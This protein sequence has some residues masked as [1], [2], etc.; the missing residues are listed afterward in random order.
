MGQRL[1]GFG[2]LVLRP[3]LRG[4]TKTLGPLI[5]SALPVKSPWLNAIEATWVH[6]KRRV[7]E[8]DRLLTIDELADRVSDAYGCTHEPHLAIP[9]KAA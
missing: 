1:G 5:S 7:L 2:T 6:R 4:P 8:A 9:E 3:K